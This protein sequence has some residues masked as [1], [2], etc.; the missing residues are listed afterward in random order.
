[1]FIGSGNK[2]FAINTWKTYIFGKEHRRNVGFPVDLKDGKGAKKFAQFD[3]QMIRELREYPIPTIEIALNENTNLDEIINL[4]VD[5][6]QYG[7]KV[8]RLNIV[9]ALRQ[10][11]P[12]L[13]DIYKLIAEKQTRQQ[14]VFTKKKRTSFVNVLKRLNIISGVADA[15]AQADRMWEKLLELALFI[16]SNGRHRKPSEILKTFI[17]SADTKQEKLSKEEK[18]KLTNTFTFLE[19]AYRNSDIASGRLATDQTHF[20]IVA[21]SLLS[22]DLLTAFTED[23]LVRKLAKFARLVDGKDDPAYYT[24]TIAQAIKRY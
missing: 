22:G 24:E 16:R 23:V 14:D 17:K 8:T 13:E 9:R 20:Y 21:S 2:E 11:D 19:R 4:F 7:A 5:I 15:A 12:L 10:K 6:N 1:M 3:E 18:R